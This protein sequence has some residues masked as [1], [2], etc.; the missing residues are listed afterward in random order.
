MTFQKVMAFLAPDV[1]S[2]TATGSLAPQF[3]LSVEARFTVSRGGS[4][5]DIGGARAGPE[6]IPQETGKLDEKVP[7]G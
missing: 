4:E 7:P 3:I 5:L 1:T 2:V 6:A